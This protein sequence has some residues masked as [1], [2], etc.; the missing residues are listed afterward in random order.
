[1]QKLA[2]EVVAF[3]EGTAPMSRAIGG[4]EERIRQTEP[5]SGGREWCLRP[6]QEGMARLRRSLSPLKD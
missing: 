6:F 2:A 1:M 4:N 5:H 3:E